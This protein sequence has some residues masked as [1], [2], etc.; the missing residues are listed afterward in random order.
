MKNNKLVRILLMGALFLAVLTGCGK[1]AATKVADASEDIIK[2]EKID[3]GE[4]Y[5]E[6]HDIQHMSSGAIRIGISDGKGLNSR[7]FESTN[8][9]KSWQKID[10]LNEKVSATNNDFLQFYLGNAGQVF[11][12]VVKEASS[13]DATFNKKSQYFVIDQDQ[14]VT[15]LP[16]TVTEISETDE[17]HAN[18]G[19]ESEHIEINSL[20]KVEFI[21]EGQL[22]AVDYNKTGYLI[23]SQTGKI[24]QTFKFIDGF[25]FADSLFADKENV[26]FYSATGFIAYNKKTGKLVTDTQLEKSVSQG[27]EEA[28]NQN[29][30]IGT[31]MYA[32]E[33]ATQ[34]YFTNGLGVYTYNLSDKKVKQ[35]VDLTKTD[36]SLNQDY[37][38]LITLLDNTNYLVAVTDNNSQ[39][40]SIYLSTKYSGKK[41]TEQKEQRT[42][43]TI[44]TLRESLDLKKVTDS[45]KSKNPNVDINIQVGIDEDS[46]QTVSDAISTLNTKM[47][48]KKGP[49]IILADGLPVTTYIE[50]GMLMNLQDMYNELKKE[51]Q[52]FEN[53]A[54]AYQAKEGLFAIPQGFSYMTVTAKKG[55][56][57]KVNTTE[58]L[59]QYLENTPSNVGVENAKM[60]ASLLYYGSI[61][62]WFDGKTINQE[63]LKVFFEQHKKLREKI[64]LYEAQQIDFNQELYTFYSGN[65]YGFME[66]LPDKESIDIALDYIGLSN[67]AFTQKALVKK[68]YETTIFN[69]LSEKQF[70]PVGIMSVS[71]SSKNQELAQ[72]FVKLTL[73]KEG[74]NLAGIPTNKN[75]LKQAFKQNIEDT[76][77]DT[78]LTETDYQQLVDSLNQLETPVNLNSVISETVINQLEAYELNGEGLENAVSNVAKKI[79]LYMAE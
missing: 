3:L 40:Q 24:L 65:F 11:V 7:V 6:V 8:K 10:T 68:E 45:F 41:A 74:T 17:E 69:G 57:D 9:G 50:K 15:E 2:S 14:K 35:V 32:D 55:L 27:L 49:D 36:L 22:L 54:T 33:K 71:S 43:L 73:S 47:L 42:A 5:E 21:D 30:Q 66:D 4:D 62:E 38:R 76:R 44:W 46:A 52:L 31:S 48:A 23:D 77:N 37:A 61:P 75:Q 18:H 64:D 67:S 20:S 58:K 28:Y 34:I 70:I 60:L 13:Y 25:E 16:L 78:P 56:V 39:K 51:D 79:D 53:I 19:H 63:K 26:Y 29:L 72:K 1:N 12:K 59:L